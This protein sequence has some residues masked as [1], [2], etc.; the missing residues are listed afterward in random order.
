MIAIRPMRDKD[1]DAM[2]EVHT[3]AVRRACAPL[4]DPDVVD[5]WL[6][7]RTPGG[8]VSAAADG[9]ERFW[10]GVIDAERVV[11]FASWRDDELISLFVDPD[12][13]GRGIGRRLFDACQDDAAA[14][15][16]GIVR[17]NS[18]LNARTFYEAYGFREV[19]RGYNEKR[20]KRIPHIE[21]VRG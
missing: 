3:K 8:Y 17:L 16:N 21:M 7:G 18:T 9:G 12:C 20:H 2:H 1:A 13:H 6:F 5:A 15:G 4:L 14:N 10:V 11:G 19:G